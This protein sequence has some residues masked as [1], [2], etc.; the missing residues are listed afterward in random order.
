M[1]PAERPSRTRRAGNRNG[2]VVLGTGGSA[3]STATD[4]QTADRF[5]KLTRV[6]IT[7]PVVTVT[8]PTEAVQLGA[9]AA[10]SW[11]ATD[12]ANGSGLATPAEG[13]IG[14]DTS[15]VGAKTVTVPAGT[16]TD[17]AGN[18]SAAVSCG[19]AVVYDW[20]GFA[21]PVDSGDVVNSVKAGSAVPIKFTLNG[22]QG[23]DILAAGS[24]TVQFGTCAPSA[25]VDEIE[26]TV[27]AGASGLKYDAD[28]DQYVYV[29]KTD[30]SWAGRCATFSLEAG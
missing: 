6:D 17:A 2:T 25:T 27:T 15:S 21:Q 23:T 3:T 7:A 24:P 13:S 8:C 11:R 9:T 29:W 22:D 18:S 4:A 5:W 19:Y 10:A 1:R 20:S 30:K 12:E 16:A 26:Q 28:A 14:L